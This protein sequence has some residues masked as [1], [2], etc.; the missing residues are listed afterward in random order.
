MHLTFF[1]G[2]GFEY[3]SPVL[4]M[5]FL[6]PLAYV[7]SLHGGWPSSLG[8]REKKAVYNMESWTNELWNVE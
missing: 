7:T 1:L 6:P 4:L 2:N 3:V 8:Y 5:T